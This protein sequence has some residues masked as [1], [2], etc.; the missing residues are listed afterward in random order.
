MYTSFNNSRHI[1][2][3]SIKNALTTYYKL[4]PVDETR[5]KRRD[6]WTKSI[7]KEQIQC[8]SEHRNRPLT[9]MRKGI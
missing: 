5:A 2:I 6:G 1:L 9:T 8:I 3:H 7:E 4:S